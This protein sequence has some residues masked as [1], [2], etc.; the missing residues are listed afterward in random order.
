[1]AAHSIM[2]SLKNLKLAQKAV[3]QQQ[4]VIRELDALVDDIERCETTIVALKSELEAVNERHKNRKTTREDIAYLTDLLKCANKKLT[5]E[6]HI[7]SLQKRTP[8]TLERMSRMINDP[9]N[10]PSD[11]LRAA[12]LKSLQGIQQAMERLQAVKVE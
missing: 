2:S 10:P 7:A 11:E 9:K 5:W 12:M 4:E 3:I 1:M 8:A 6:K